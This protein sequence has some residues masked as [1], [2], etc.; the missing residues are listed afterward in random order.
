MDGKPD[1]IPGD[2]ILDAY[3]KSPESIRAMVTTLLKGDTRQ[4]ICG[5]VNTNGDVTVD[6]ACDARGSLAIVATIVH[7]MRK[8]NG[9]LWLNQLQTMIKK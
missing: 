5:C 4:A 3:I 7:T 1:V 9:D 8:Y 6:T 2:D